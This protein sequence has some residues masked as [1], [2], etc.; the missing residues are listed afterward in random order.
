MNIHNILTTPFFYNHE[1]ETIIKRTVYTTL[2]SASKSQK[3]LFL[4]TLISISS[5]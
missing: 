1:D 3:V 4:S 5:V 2:R